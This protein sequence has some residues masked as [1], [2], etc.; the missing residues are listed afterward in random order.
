MATALC[1]RYS[2]PVAFATIAVISTVGA[3]LN[4]FIS[5]MLLKDI[6]I[7]FCAQASAV[8]AL[9]IV[10]ILRTCQSIVPCLPLDMLT[11]AVVC[12]AGELV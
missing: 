1:C 5:M 9:H 11:V 2:F 7:G 3:C 6:V 12:S 10:P 4:Y 8:S